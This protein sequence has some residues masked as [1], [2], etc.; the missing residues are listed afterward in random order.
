MTKREG[1]RKKKDVEAEVLGEG[2]SEATDDNREWK[3]SKAKQ[4]KESK[5]YE[6]EWC[7]VMAMMSFAH[8]V[9]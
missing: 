3:E 4:A 5:E 6:G 8:F 2:K 7:V 1:V 9:C